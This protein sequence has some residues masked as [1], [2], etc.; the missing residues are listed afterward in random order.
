MLSIVKMVE[1]VGVKVSYHLLIL[2]LF[3][4]NVFSGILRGSLYA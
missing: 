3:I 4:S 1:S 2:K